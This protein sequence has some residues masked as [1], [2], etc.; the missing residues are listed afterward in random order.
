MNGAMDWLLW[1]KGPGFQ[2]ALTVFFVGMAFQ[3]ASILLAG[4]K[5]DL[6]EPRGNPAAG[7]RRLL[8]RRMLPPPGMLERAPATYVAGY[9]FHVGI[10]VVLLLSA[11]HIE[12]FHAL[13]GIGWPGLPTALID[14]VTVV[15]LLALFVL[16][17]TRLTD[18]VRRFLARP[19]DYVVWALTVVPILT[20]WLAVNR[21]GPSYTGML[22]AHVLSV[23]LLLVAFPFTKLGHALTL[24]T[25]RWYQGT[26]LG[27]K[28]VQ[29]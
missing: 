21:F 5:T 17:Y 27:H 11:P 7:G 26:I 23:D 13:L 16:L 28:G 10:A 4:R 20:G 9:L 19:E 3:L 12:I 14:A 1:A 24:F 22:A 8:W 29:P 25:S 2:I 15:T 18:P 6:S